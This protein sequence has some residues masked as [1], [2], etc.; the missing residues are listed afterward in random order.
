MRRRSFPSFPAALRGP[1]RSVATRRSAAPA[2]LFPLALALALVTQGCVA[3]RAPRK[4]IEQVMTDRHPEVVRVSVREADGDVSRR[5]VMTPWIESDGLLGYEA[6]T[7][8]ARSNVYR[9]MP[10]KT[11]VAIPLSSIQ[12]TEIRKPAVGAGTIIVGAVAAALL[13]AALTADFDTGGDGGTLSDSGNMGS[14]PV[15]SSWDGSRWRL[16]SATFGGAIAECLRRTDVDLLEFASASPD[17]RVHL[18]MEDPLDETEHVD[19]VTL[20]VVEHDRG[21]SIAPDAEGRLCTLGPLIAPLSA[22]DFAGNDALDRVA[23]L[24]DW[25]WESVPAIRDTSDAQTLRDGLVLRFPCPS[26]AS[27]GKLVVD[28]RNSSWAN[29][30]MYVFVAAH[31]SETGAWYEALAADPERARRAIPFLFRDAFLSVELLTDQGWRPQGTLSE[32]GPEVRKR[33]V[34]RLDLRDAAG[35]ETIEVRVRSLPSFW[36]IDRVAIDT[37]EDGVI[38]VREIE[39]ESAADQDG[40]DIRRSIR[41]IDAEEYRMEQGDRA[42]LVFDAGGPPAEGRARS[43]VLQTS[44]WYWIHSRDDGKPDIAMLSLLERD[45]AALGR[46]A[47]ARANRATALLSRARP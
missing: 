17:G 41:R 15:V 4:P 24:D 3:W 11:R 34:C 30:L 31:G 38:D 35:E 2:I 40:K 47:V 10:P 21:V 32:A 39:A 23:A 46:L 29:Y 28:G 7:L 27:Q 6:D 22:A 42:D 14:C 5:L 33:Q 1:C 12:Q 25:S 13:V 9:V 26:G 19:R 18:A 36:V 43:F 45:P 16:D 44:G 8:A 37:S 20:L